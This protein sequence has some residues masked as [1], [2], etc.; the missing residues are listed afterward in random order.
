LGEIGGRGFGGEGSGVSWG[1]SGGSEEFAV[2]GTVEGGWCRQG[3]EDRGGEFSGG[4][5]RFFAAVIHGK[6]MVKKK[7]LIIPYFEI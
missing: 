3:R 6:I 2:R 5:F 1:G 4:S 7:H